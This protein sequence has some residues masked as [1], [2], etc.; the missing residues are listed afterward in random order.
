MGTLLLLLNNVSYY[1]LINRYYNK[2]DWYTKIILI[3]K[4]INTLIYINYKYNIYTGPIIG[5]LLY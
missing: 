3:S 1:L 5:L 4:Q 2:L